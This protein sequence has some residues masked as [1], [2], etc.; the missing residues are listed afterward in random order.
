[1]PGSPFAARESG[2]NEMSRALN[3]SSIPLSR[4]LKALV[5]PSDFP[6]LIKHKWHS[7]DASNKTYA[8]TYL[9]GRG[10]RIFMHRLILNAQKGQEVDHIDGDGLNNTR[11][12]LRFVTRQQ[13]C[14]NSGK[15]Q[16][17]TTSKYKGVSRCSVRNRWKAR[18]KINQK[19]I[20]IGRFV[21]EIDAAK[22]YDQKAIELFGSFARL[23]F[24]RPEVTQ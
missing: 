17:V 14:F 24:E 12:N 20:D 5:D 16:R 9:S 4:G 2:K 23:N 8:S 19:A 1:M 7:I 15:T 10:T 22:A 18:I 11:L 21:N 6:S 13:N 3:Y